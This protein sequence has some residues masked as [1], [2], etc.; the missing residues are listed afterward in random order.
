MNLFSY[1]TFRAGNRIN[2][3]VDVREGYN[4]YFYNDPVSGWTVMPWDLDMM[5][6][7]ETHWS[8]TIQQKACLNVPV[9]DIE[10]RNRAREMLD[11]LC[12]DDSADG[13]QM[14]QL[15][16]EYA[17]M[18]N[19][20]GQA[21]T[22]SDVD[23]S[24]WNYHPRTRPENPA[25]SPS[26]P[27]GQGNHRG[28]WF[29][30]PFQDAR[31]GG[32]Y[33]RTLDSSDHEGSMKFLKE[34]V[35]DTFGGGAWAPGNGQQK[36]YGFEFISSDA[37]DPAIPD[38]PTISYEGGAGFPSDDLQFSSSDFL[39]PQ[40]DDSFAAMMW[41]V[42]EI[43]NPSTP[44]YDPTETYKYK[45]EDNWD[46]GEIPTFSSNFT[47][48]PG[49]VRVGHTYR[50]RVKYKDTTGRWSH[51][52]EPVQFVVS[53]PDLSPWRENLMITELMY[54]PSSATLD[55]I[56]AGFSGSD[57]EYIELKNV[58]QTTLDLTEIRFTKGV[59]FDFAGSAITSLAPGSYV[60]IARNVAGF[61]S[62]YGAGLPVAGAYAP[63][64]LSNG[65]ENVKLSFGQGSAIHDF[66]YDDSSP[67]PEAADGSGPSLVLILP[68]TR[69]DHGIATNWRASSDAGNPGSS[70]ASSFSG[71]PNAD[72][73]DNGLSA[74]L[75]YAFGSSDSEASDP[76]PVIPHINGVGALGLTFPRSLAAE[77]IMISFEKSIDLVS[78]EP[79]V[80]LIKE[81]SIYQGDGTELETW[82]LPTP[83]ADEERCFLR[84]RVELFA[85]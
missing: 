9:L 39:D 60:V 29:A 77:D 3:N 18:V 66:V 85:P 40:G 79:D 61:E 13:G 21:L 6:I 7:A 76:S 48:P 19:P 45:I 62:R 53:E 11:L 31:I 52:S 24:M 12:S 68:E 75:E 72:E 38:Q 63:D 84:I 46:S 50:A 69:P 67:W 43:A 8:G 71:D 49:A 83:A 81:D 30:T 42:G 17:Q 51:W 33:T 35:T 5:F 65:G 41:R 10:Y 26:P 55:E 36:G 58:G 47:I 44:L 20:P 14:A 37:S 16:D 2:G 59:D 25:T 54:H 78:W 73:N 15:I 34:Y 57:F 28:N 23:E 70:D 74:L 64:S 4:H 22:W 80:T 32:G 56:N 82:R 27:S 1:Y